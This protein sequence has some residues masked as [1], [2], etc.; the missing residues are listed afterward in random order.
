MIWVFLYV[1]GWFRL[2]INCGQAYIGETAR[3]LEVRVN[4]HS[5]VDGSRNQPAFNLN[6]NIPRDI[7]RLALE[8][9]AELSSE[10]KRNVNKS[11]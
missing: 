4:E 2:P 10:L 8:I 7:P 1:F 9:R 5:D 11:A 3:N 6:F